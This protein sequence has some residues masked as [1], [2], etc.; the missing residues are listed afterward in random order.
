MEVVVVPTAVGGTGNVHG[1]TVV[2]EDEAVLF[3]SVQDDLIGGGI[4]GDIEASFEAEAGAH[5]RC[6]GVGACGGPVRSGGNKTGTGVLQG[7]ADGVIESASGDFVVTNQT[8]K[9]RETCSIGAGP[10]V[11]TLLVGKKIPDGPRIGVPTGGLRIGTIELVQKTIGFIEN[12]DVAVA[13]AGIGIALD[14]GGKRNGHGARVAF[15]AVGLIVDGN[16]RLCGIDNGVRNADVG[17]V[18]FAGAKIGMDADGRADE[19]D[20]GGGIGID[21]GRGDVC[22]PEIV[23][24]KGNEAAEAGALTGEQL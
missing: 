13:G 8:W 21:A 11:R 9:N 18:V 2:G 15:A 14:G 1:G 20:D 4:A 24:R 22:V 12:E 23:R 19:I 17:T 16:E 6:E 10:G 5:G 3:H 7:E